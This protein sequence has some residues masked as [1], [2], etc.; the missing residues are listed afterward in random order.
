MPVSRT[1]KSSR[2][3]G[4]SAQAE[5][6]LHE[7]LRGGDPLAGMDARLA[8]NE[9]LP[10]FGQPLYPEG[11]PRAVAILEALAANLPQAWQRI[12]TILD[13]AARLIPQRPNVDF[14]LAAAT[15]ALGLPQGAALALFILG[16]S[17]G[18]IAHASEQLQTGKFIRP[19]ARY[20]GP[21][22]GRTT[23]PDRL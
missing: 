9:M 10:G 20:V 12:K 5:V 4:A 8:R 7:L 19:R 18:W 22:P 13:A 23:D 15:A 14:A 17:V 21:V 6:L 16:R 3:G 11:D 2:H 1:V